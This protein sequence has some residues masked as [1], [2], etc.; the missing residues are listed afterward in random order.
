MTDFMY[1][2]DWHY[3]G[4]HCAA[5]GC[6]S[7]NLCAF[8]LVR[9]EQKRTLDRLTMCFACR[10]TDWLLVNEALLDKATEA[11]SADGWVFIAG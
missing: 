8:Y 7:T 4:T 9:P 11:L 3:G 6:T 5:A 1:R 2:F 10:D